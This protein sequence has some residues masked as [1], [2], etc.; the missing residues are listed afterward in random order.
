MKFCNIIF[1][2]M[3]NT[4]LVRRFRF[5]VSATE[6]VPFAFHIVSHALKSL[7]NMFSVCLCCSA[8]SPTEAISLALHSVLQNTQKTLLTWRNFMFKTV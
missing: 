1:E 5:A 6:A 3:W 8:E 2:S 4:F 7:W